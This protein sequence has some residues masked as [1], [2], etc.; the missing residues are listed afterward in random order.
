MVR[1]KSAI[2]SLIEDLF[3]NYPNEE[4][5]PHLRMDME[6]VY[7]SNG[8]NEGEPIAEERRLV[9]DIYSMQLWCLH[10][11]DSTR[12]IYKNINNWK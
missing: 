6:G 9:C 7:C 3:K 4:K 12:C 1:I 2:D 11:S 8:L 5:C 10:K